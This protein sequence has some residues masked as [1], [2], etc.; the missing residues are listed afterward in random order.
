MDKYTMTFN[1]TEA[2]EKK[3]FTFAL[4]EGWE[5]GN[6]KRMGYYV[7]ATYNEVHNIIMTHDR[8]VKINKVLN[9][10]R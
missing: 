10:D 8:D 7:E 6:A 9:G 3:Q 5:D 2:D 1:S 4:Q